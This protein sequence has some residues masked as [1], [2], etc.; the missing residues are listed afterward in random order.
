MQLTRSTTSTIIVLG[1]LLVAAPTWAGP[2][3][4]STG[5]LYVK[6][7]QG[8]FLADSFRDASGR[9]NEGTS[10]LGAT[11][12][13]YLE[14]GVLEGLH[15]WGYLPY[16]LAQNAMQD[17]GSRWLRSSGGDALLGL[18]WT[19][20]F[21]TLPFPAAVKLEFKVPLYDVNG[22][23]GL[24]GPRFP[25]PGDGQLDVTFWLSGGGSLGSMAPLY[26]Y[27]ELGYRLR[28]EAF[29]GTGPFSAEFGDGIAFFASVGYTLLDWA[30]VAL[31]TG[32][33]I[34]FEEDLYTKG[35]VTLGPALYLPI[36]KGLAAEASLDPMVYTN[37]NASPGV[38][39]S[40]GLSFKN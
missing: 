20:H 18:Q 27:G 13:V 3:T 29:V 2:W 32:G 37:N 31:N 1:G 12:S 11:T 19:P 17:D 21:V 6:L 35:Y 10:Y 22:V 25:A 4:K 40:V 24:Y 14:V 34:P 9:L 8:F 15:A 26:F 23:E 7:G 30:T 39:F 5:E 36:Y 28:T 38:G 16:V 33:I